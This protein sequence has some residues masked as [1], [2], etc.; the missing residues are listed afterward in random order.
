[1]EL[2]AAEIRQAIRVALAEDIGS[3]DATTLAVVPEGAAAGAVMRARETLVIAGIAFA[4]TAFSELS[5][6]IKIDRLA[7]DGQHVTAG[8][9]LLRISGAP[10]LPRPQWDSVLHFAGQPNGCL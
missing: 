2:P 5:S 10:G 1:M 9:E 3:G 7:K 8:G 4:E 6:S